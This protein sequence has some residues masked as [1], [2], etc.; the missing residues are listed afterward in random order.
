[1]ADHSGGDLVEAEPDLHQSDAQKNMN[2]F[3]ENLRLRRQNDD[4]V[5]EKDQDT[6]ENGDFPAPELVG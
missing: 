3:V 6:Q 5:I 2:G 4:Q 1:M